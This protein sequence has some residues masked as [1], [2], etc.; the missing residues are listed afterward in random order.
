MLN[1][2]GE[3]NMAVISGKSQKRMPQKRWKENYYNFLKFFIN[4][5]GEEIR[6]SFKCFKKQIK[7]RIWLRSNY[8]RYRCSICY[9]GK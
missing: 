3:V 7:E 2:W 5:N 9:L 4:Q 6:P 8:D 1:S